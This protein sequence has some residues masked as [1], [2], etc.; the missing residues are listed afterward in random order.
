MAMWRG[1]AAVTKNDV[2]ASRYYHA[3]PTPSKESDE[4]QGKWINHWHQLK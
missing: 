1:G 2:S 3:I 4:R